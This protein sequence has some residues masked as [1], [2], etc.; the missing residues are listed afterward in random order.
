M[1]K[2]RPLCS[3]A[4]LPAARA[5]A[6]WRGRA[7]RSGERSP[8]SRCAACVR[9]LR[10]ALCGGG[11]PRHPAE[12]HGAPSLPALEGARAQHHPPSSSL[13]RSLLGVA[14]LGALPLGALPLGALLLP[15]GALPPRG[16]S[17][18]VWTMRRA[19]A[20]AAAAAGLA[21][22]ATTPRAVHVAATRWL[23]SARS[24]R[25]H[26]KL[27]RLSR[28]IRVAC[29]MRPAPRRLTRPRRPP[30]CR[31]HHPLGNG[32]RPGCAAG[33]APRSQRQRRR[34]KAARWEAGELVLVSVGGRRAAVQPV[35]PR[36]MSRLGSP[37]SRRQEE[38][39]ATGRWP[40]WT[41]CA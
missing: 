15:L 14:P 12:T 10:C 28:P 32:T 25:K 17:Y 11:A 5:F 9:A 21:H 13:Q 35:W 37:H 20:R 40:P 36:P 7:L 24:H 29:A 34:L 2:V 4:L 22:E 33:P 27:A 39:P 38:P 30:T 3:H 6:G 31:R 18:A 41:A 1:A 16:V 26:G 8:M 19:L 23:H